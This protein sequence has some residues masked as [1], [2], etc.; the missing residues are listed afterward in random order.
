VGFLL[1]AALLAGC[2]GSGSDPLTKAEYIAAADRICT[3]Q[4]FSVTTL[5][6]KEAE[7]PSGGTPSFN[8]E[9]ADDKAG[10][11]DELSAL[12]PP[13]ADRDVISAWLAARRQQIDLL[14]EG[15]EA[16]KSNDDSR[17]TVLTDQFGEARSRDLATA[18]DYGMEVC[19]RPAGTL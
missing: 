11:L 8:R 3:A 17:V 4:E 14:R 1:A 16:Q 19:S 7:L 12:E 5:D 10:I 6:G 2:G 9:F 15:A 18:R 13:T